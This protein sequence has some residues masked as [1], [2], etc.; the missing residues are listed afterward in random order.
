[1]RSIEGI[2]ILSSFVVLPVEGV[3]PSPLPRRKA[4]YFIDLRGVALCKIFQTK[5][6]RPKYCKQMGY[7][8]RV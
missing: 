3:P 5:E 8:A 2:S 7:G 4:F 6:L 1:M